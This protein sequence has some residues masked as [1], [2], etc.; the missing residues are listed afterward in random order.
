MATGCLGY[1]YGKNKQR[2]KAMK[3]LEHLN[4][5]AQ[6][7]YIPHIFKAVIHCGLDENESA[8]DLLEKACS[9]GETMCMLLK[10]WCVFDGLGSDKRFKAL[11]KK[12]K[13]N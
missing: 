11:L 6:E 12:L 3:M 13:L 2:D 5:V 1:A 9:N 10:V 4:T 7:R 8:L